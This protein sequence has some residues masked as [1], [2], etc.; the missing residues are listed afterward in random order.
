M[1]GRVP[2]SR[3]QQ[4]EKESFFNNLRGSIN[5]RDREQAPARPFTRPPLRRP[6]PQVEEDTPRFVAAPSR[7]PSSS[8]GFG[9]RRQPI[10][11]KPDTDTTLLREVE[12]E[13]GRRELQ[14]QQV[15]EELG[16][17]KLQQQQ[18]KEE[19]AR[20]ELQ[21]QQVQE[22]LARRELQRQ[23]VEEE[24][25]RREL[26]QQQVEEEL[27][28]RRLQQEQVKEEQARRDSANLGP[29][30]LDSLLSRGRQGQSGQS[31]GSLRRAPLSRGEGGRGRLEVLDIKRPP[32]QPQ[33][34]EQE[35]FV[36][37]FNSFRQRNSG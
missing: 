8:S 27:A 28:R 23:Q 21:Q 36:T 20:R 25:A 30:D 29:S 3:L 34:E 35:D 5:G 24:L 33:Q 16:R 11:K 2:V 22:E 12:A 15:Q 17:R 14:Q 32:L 31:R 37:N 6:T 19:L 4:K 10:R 1:R 26:Q 7:A 9:R 18:V 13:L